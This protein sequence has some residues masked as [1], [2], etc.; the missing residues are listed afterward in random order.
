MGTI[1]LVAGKYAIIV[2]IVLF[3]V[4]GVFLS[5]DI[6]R[7]LVDYDEAT[8]AKV[9][10]DTL[11]TG[12][13]TDLYHFNQLWF[14]KPPLY[15]WMAMGSVKLFDEHEFAF[16]IP[17][18]IASILCYW[19]VYLIVAELTGD[20]LAAT[21]GFFILLLSN[22]FFT[23]GREARLDSAV[24]AAILAALYFFIKSW[25]EEKFRV[26]SDRLSV[27]NGG[28]PITRIQLLLQ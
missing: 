8:Y 7:Q 16:R 26:V 24:T 9:V 19:L 28:Q 20:T 22:S 3:C 4:A 17:S 12:Q 18:I 27:K 6:N 15:L 2:Q 21:F 14:E 23:Y 1:K 13:A 5:I 10:V 11:H 25:R